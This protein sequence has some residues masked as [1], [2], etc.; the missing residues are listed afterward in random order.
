MCLKLHYLKVLIFSA[1][2]ILD[3]SGY[4]QENKPE[5]EEIS[6]DRPDQTEASNTVPKR[7]IQ[8]ETG[9]VF[10]SDKTGDLRE[11]VL[12]YPTTLVRIG[13]L[14]GVEF[15]FINQFISSQSILLN[16]RKYHNGFDAFALG[17]KI[18]LCKEKGLRPEISFMGHLTLPFGSKIYRPSVIAPDFKFSLSN[19]ISERFKIGYNLG[20]YWQDGITNGAAFYTVAL[21]YTISEKWGFYIEAFGNKARGDYSQHSFDGGFT[22]LAR[23][24]IQLDV[25]AGHKITSNAPDYYLSTGFSIRLPR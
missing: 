5:V 4:S 12:S 20:W 3:I 13:I 9:V 16:E 17:T 8:V 23:P 22:F 25:S 2:V 11:R 10:Q 14:K 19:T 7:T 1:F 24:N 21:G 15:R 6:T 18:Y